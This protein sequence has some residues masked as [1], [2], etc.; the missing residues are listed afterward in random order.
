[1]IIA[2]VPELAYDAARRSRV[3]AA[4]EAASAYAGRF[5]LLIL[6]SGCRKLR[7]HLIDERFTGCGGKARSRSEARSHG[8]GSASGVECVGRQRMKDRIRSEATESR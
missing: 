4:A 6:V 2:E 5:G 8:A 7:R 1:M 3:S